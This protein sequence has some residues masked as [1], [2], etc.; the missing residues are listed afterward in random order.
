MGTRIQHGM[1]HV[2]QTVLDFLFPPHCLK[3]DRIAPWLCPDCSAEIPYSEPI[4]NADS[5]LLARCA[6]A[7]FG[8]HIRDVIHALKYENKRVAAVPL[9][10][11]M[12]YALQKAAWHVDIVVPLPLHP[13]RLSQRGY[14]QADLLGRELA[15][16]V[17][18]AYC[19]DGVSRVRDT[20]SQ[21]GLSARERHANVA[22]AFAVA[23]T[24]F[25]GKRV[26]LVDD[27][28]T[29]GATLNACAEALLVG[30]AA[31]VYGLTVAYAPKPDPD[32]RIS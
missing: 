30:G 20:A 5:A 25:T 14:N 9:A 23:E 15:Q 26:L 8:G 7:E 12:A 28:Y 24:V 22:G 17:H 32:T 21:V 4:L 18:I 10:D 13:K 2:V 31:S 19:S 6:T 27:V 11:R 3:C 16:K 29:T 1:Q